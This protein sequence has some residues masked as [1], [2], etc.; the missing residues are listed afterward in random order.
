[1][2]N[3]REFV[4]ALCQFGHIGRARVTGAID[5]G[6]VTVQ[7]GVGMPT[8]ECDVLQDDAQRIALGVGDLVLV[9]IAEG[10]D[11][12]GV[13]LGKIGRYREPDNVLSAT[14]LAARPETLTLEARGDVVLRNQAARVT[15]RRDGEIDIVCNGLSARS[16][17]L[18]QLLAPVIKLN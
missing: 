12:A 16:H 3:L 6:P 18:L 17:R 9:W 8:I 10:R 1:V 5:G 11:G 14:A 4:P 15:L 2:S 7:T 13:V